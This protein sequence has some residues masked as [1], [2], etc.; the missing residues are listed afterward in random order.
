MLRF[1]V[2]GEVLFA[3]FLF[4]S[5]FKA[6][7]PFV[8]I[9]L[10]L[11]FLVMS[12][13]AGIKRLLENPYILKKA[14][15]PITIYLLLVMLMITSLVYTL[16]EEYALSKTLTF[17]TLTFWSFAGVFILIKNKESLDLFMKGLL[18]YGLLTL[19]MVFINYI[20]GDSSAFRVGVGAEGA[21]N[22]LGLGRLAGV[23]SIILI[24]GLFYRQSRLRN[25]AIV[26]TLIG[27]S[28]FILVLTG[29]R[30]PFLAL[31]A[32]L[33]LI[34]LFSIKINGGEV[35]IKKGLLLSV[36]IMPIVLFSI[37]P[38]IQKSD[39]FYRLTKFYES[40]GG[41]SVQ[42]R[43]DMIKG[44][45]EMWKQSPIAG[46]G[47]GSFPILYAGVDLKNR[48]YP[49]NIFAEFLSELGLIGFSLFLLLIIIAGISVIGLFKRERNYMQISVVLILFFLILNASSSGDFNDNRWLFCFIALTIM[50]PAYKTKGEIPDDFNHKEPAV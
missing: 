7:F 6:Y 22:V 3:G 16:G 41:G 14:I 11:L 39:M 47:I 43:T 40:G 8:P 45:I 4:S 38:F 36:P 24:V 48:V 28:L 13:F 32:S 34:P 35:K 37:K 25:K 18:F 31:I 33:F 29:S 19:G 2:K 44:S 10:T 20:S 5:V 21:G 46:N 15:S 50:V 42:S 17:A 27:I 26:S 12:L 23:V 30:M 1:F 9:D 49:H